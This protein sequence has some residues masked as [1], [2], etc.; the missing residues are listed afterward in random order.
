M[1]TA[2]IILAI[3]KPRAKNNHGLLIT[4]MMK[5]V[6]TSETS[7]NYRTTQHNIPEENNVL[8]NDVFSTTASVI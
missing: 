1:L 3:I 6:N 7:A 8:F 2:S 4:F 5:A